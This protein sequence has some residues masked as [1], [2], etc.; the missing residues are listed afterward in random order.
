MIV[1]HNSN[2]P[3][4]VEAALSYLRHAEEVSNPSNFSGE[5]KSGRNLSKTEYE[6]KDSALILLLQYFNQPLPNIELPPTN[7]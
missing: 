4:Q 6:V 2:I 3:G 1:V 7:K 5:A